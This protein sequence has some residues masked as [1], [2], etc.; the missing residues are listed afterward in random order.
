MFLKRGPGGGA[1]AGMY[2]PRIACFVCGMEGPADYPL[3]AMPTP[4]NSSG[5]T[6]TPHFPFLLHHPPPPGS[7]GMAPGAKEA[8]AC[9]P[10][11]LTLMRQWETY[12]S[13]RVPKVKRIYWVKRQDGMPFLSAEAQ[14]SAARNLAQN[15]GNMMRTET[16]ASAPNMPAPVEVPPTHHSSWPGSN[17]NSTPAASRCGNPGGGSSRTVTS[18]ESQSGANPNNLATGSSLPPPAGDDDSALDL[19]SGSRENVKSRSSVV[20][21]V[22]IHSSYQSEGGGSSTDIL[23]LTL[24]DK[25]AKYEVCYVCG[26][27]FKRGTL[28]YSFAKQINKEPFYQSLT[29]HPRPPRSRP[30]DHAG[31][32]QTCDECHNHLYL[33]WCQFETDEVPH[34]DRNYVLRK[35]TASSTDPA[36]F[37]CYICALDYPS[38]SLRLLYARPNSEEEPYYPFIAELKPQPGASPISPQGM[39]QVCTICAKNTKEKHHGLESHHFSSATSPALSP[40]CSMSFSNM[41]ILILLVVLILDLPILSTSRSYSFLLSFG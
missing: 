22:S 7:Q 13:T 3:F 17:A 41:S 16:S 30:M 18:A 31:R 40:V 28:S 1:A 2:P 6:P 4:S 32:V 15:S 20:S 27:E 36:S 19:S 37:V 8:K 26:E 38:S 24:P 12:E 21:A 34:A 23:D 39:V 10:C 33:Q 11:Y 29:Q 25:N 5:A 14:M 35:R 9:R